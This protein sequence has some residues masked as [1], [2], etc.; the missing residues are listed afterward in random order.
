MQASWL[1][2]TADALLRLFR[3]G[4][5]IS[6][7]S[8]D[9]KSCRNIIAPGV[10]LLPLL[11]GQAARSDVAVAASFDFASVADEFWLWGRELSGRR[12][13]KNRQKSNQAKDHMPLQ[14]A[15]EI[16]HQRP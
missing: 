16:S 12:A 4:L 11:L 9:T 3:C 13:G 8:S 5:A 2:S 6:L 10:F 7:S 14:S 15:E 1:R